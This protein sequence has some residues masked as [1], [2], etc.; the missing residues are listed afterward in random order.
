VHVH[1]FTIFE[2]TEQRLS[3]LELL[4][5]ENYLKGRVSHKKSEVK[6]I[7]TGIVLGVGI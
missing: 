3:Y 5:S 2:P 6:S 1:H 4:S 7:L